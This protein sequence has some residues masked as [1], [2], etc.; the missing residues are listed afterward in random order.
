MTRSRRAGMTFMELLVGL[1]LT[2][3]MA[4]AG[5]AAFGSIIDHRRVIK[6]S[7]VAMERAAALR[8]L[9]GVW[10]GS[11]TPL[12]QQGGV[13]RIGGRASSVTAVSQTISAAASS[14]DELSFVTT[15]LTPALTPSIRMRLFI[16]EDD[17]TPERGLTIEYQASNQSPLV[18]RELEPSIGALKVEYLDQRT[19][20]WRPASEA[21]AIQPIALRLA[22]FPPEHGELPPML[23]VPLI[24]RFQQP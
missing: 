10:I 17:G 8:E 21:A 16:D 22:L 11:G 13:P 20:R 9:L 12:I 15:A 7:T 5:V 2:G 24:F 6:E 18:R 3:V 14:G 1:T 23:Q 19:N 4:A